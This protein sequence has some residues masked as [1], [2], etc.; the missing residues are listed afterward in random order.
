MNS[1]GSSETAVENGRQSLCDRKPKELPVEVTFRRNEDPYVPSAVTQVGILHDPFNPF[2][3]PIEGERARAFTPDV[4]TEEEMR[5]FPEYS[6]SPV[7]EVYLMLR[8]LVLA[9][10]HKNCKNYVS[11]ESCF[12]SLYTRGLVRIWCRGA[13]YRI[14]HFLTRKGYINSGHLTNATIPL[15]IAGTVKRGTVIVIGAGPSGLSAA[16][17]LSNFGYQVTVLEGRGQAGGRCRDDSTLGVTLNMGAMIITGIDNNPITT[18]CHQL[19]HPLH[20]IM[21]DKCDLISE[22]GSKP[23]TAVDQKVD[24]HFNGAL[25]VLAK[26]R[27]SA[28]S[29]CSLEDK[30]LEI[31][32]FL[33]E[34]SGYSLTE[35]EE[36]LFHF[37][38]GNLEFACGAELSKVSA[39]NWDHNDRY[40]QFNGPHATL[41]GGCQSIFRQLAAHLNVHYDTIVTKVERRR[42]EGGDNEMCYVTDESGKVWE[43]ER[44]IV[45]VPISILKAGHIEFVPP[46]PEKKMAAM[47]KIGFG[48]I[49]KVAVSFS[50][51][52]WRCKVTTPHFFGRISEKRENRGLFAMFYDVTDKPTDS[53]GPFILVSVLCGS[54]VERLLKE[55]TSDC[56]LVEIFVDTL[57]SL[58]P[59]VDIQPPLGF[60]VSQWRREKMSMMS[61]S[62]AAVNSSGADYRTMSEDV[63]H[64]IFFA[65]EATNHL[66]PQ[67]V[68]GAYLSGIREACKIIEIDDLY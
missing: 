51:P 29:D 1:T 11:V 42:D 6:R 67:T 26:W 5:A 15:P 4:M 63:N 2:N 22:N 61:Y 37:H 55:N 13:L 35:E 64:K 19:D 10:W 41:P 32:K 7:I 53:E 8:N 62:Y 3:R 28:Q 40:P 27:Q 23:S 44:V 65:G 50:N 39:L 58:F 52:F 34:S 60:V 31:H 30:L 54:S 18:L 43:A 56:R 17:H 59:G 38:L 66:Y 47:D 21:E 12:D 20:I 45:T 24:S 68:S 57:K 25:D 48:I 49:E 9:M 36:Q 33:Q 46:L 14:I 16:R